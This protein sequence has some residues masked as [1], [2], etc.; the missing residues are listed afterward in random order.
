MPDNAAEIRQA[1]IPLMAAT[2][3]SGVPVLA[4]S[5]IVVALILFTLTPVVALGVVLVR[6]DFFQDLPH[7]SMAAHVFTYV[8]SP[9][10][11]GPTIQKFLTPAIGALIPAMYLGRDDRFAASCGIGAILVFSFSGFF[12]VSS[13]NWVFSS[14]D[15]MERLFVENAFGLDA[16]SAES[17]EAFNAKLTTARSY[18]SKSQESL[19]FVVMTV[20]GVK[21]AG[22]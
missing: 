17:R 19:L 20:L 1:P 22:K 5:F 8:T 15:L 18:V 6:S 3:L 12:A 16:D 9:D 11:L 2:S 13:L 7:S 14:A 21:F 10:D 4:L